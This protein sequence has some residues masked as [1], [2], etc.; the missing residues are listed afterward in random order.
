M[1]KRQ[2]KE[3]ERKPILYGSSLYKKGTV[4]C[5]QEESVGKLQCIVI[6]VSLKINQ[7][8]TNR[9]SE[10][11]KEGEYNVYGMREWAEDTMGEGDW[12]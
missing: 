7:W 1:R 9:G 8:H 4:T 3:V 11:L 6:P 12:P 5:A 2:Q 10:G